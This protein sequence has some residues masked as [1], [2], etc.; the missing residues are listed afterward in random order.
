M[1]TH[2]IQNDT[3]SLVINTT[4]GSVEVLYWGAPVGALDAQAL[5]D[6]STEGVPHGLSDVS[7]RPGIW[8]ENSRGFLGRPALDGH[9]G[10]YDWSPKFEVTEVVAADTTI[11]VHSADAQAELAVTVTFALQPGGVV[12]V[13]QSLT[14]TG[15]A[16]YTLNELTTFLPL[17]DRATQVLDFTGR[18]TKERQAQHHTIQVGEWLRESREGRSGHDHSIISIAHTESAS[19]QSGEAWSVGVLWSGNCRHI[20][21]KTPT[22]RQSIGAGELLLPGEVI[23]QPGET[24][25]AP[26]VAAAYSRDGFDGITNAHH[27][28]LRSRPEHPT[29]VRPRPLTLNVWEAVYFDHDLEQ[30]T[31]LA[32]VAAEIGVERFVLDDGWFG[33]RRDDTAGLG[34]WVVSPEAWPNGLAPLIDMVKAHGMEFGL[35]FE[36]EMV[37]PDSDL[38]REHPEWILHMGGRAPIMGRGQHVLDITH[39]GAF[40]HV[41]AQVDAVLSANDISYIKWDHNMVLL[42]PGHLGRAAVRAQNQAIYRLFDELKRRH[43]GLEIESCASGGGRID[44]G[45]AFHA[46]RFWTSDCNDALERQSIQRFTQFAIPPEML[47][48]HIGPHRAHTTHRTHS[49]AFRASTALFGHAGLEW[50]LTE[51]TPEERAALKAW[52]DYYKANRDLLHGG[53]TVRV[54]HPDDAVYVHGVVSQDRARAICA[55]VALNATGGSVPAALRIPGLDPAG[56][57]SVTRV[58]FAGG[59][60]HVSRALPGWWAAASDGSFQIS[61]E[62]LESVGLRPPI[63][64]PETAF[65]LEVQR[66]S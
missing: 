54:D 49:L 64:D 57:Y 61:G 6:A 18:W 11:S 39:P 29:A 63:I 47:G 36:G 42:E 58:E 4:G 37:Q 16:A 24:Y 55:Y 34:D 20:V 30:L 9:R 8:R 22:G 23:L 44:L 5:R 19:Y 38:F 62:L 25:E 35:W 21:E 43:P 46:D 65:V 12:L 50:N 56:T 40:D 15:G 3:V 53:R 13:S 28:W 27:R 14:N 59:P 26:S 66:V 32:E 1:S 45:M 51:T 17:P 33:A 10:G 31:R 41:L 52:A 48:T 2:H 7:P 60:T